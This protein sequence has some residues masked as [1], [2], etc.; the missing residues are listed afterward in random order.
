MVPKRSE[1]ITCPNCG[2]EYFPDEIFI[3]KSFFGNAT[4]IVR[5]ENG[6]IIDYFGDPSD[7]RETFCCNKCNT[8]FNVVAK[9]Q[10]TTASRKTQN[11][12]E[13]YVS[14]LYTNIYTLNEDA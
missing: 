12:N 5:D 1:V 8:N 7:T 10:F 3:P 11:I 9:I 6:K 13:E 4:D 14:R 2:Y